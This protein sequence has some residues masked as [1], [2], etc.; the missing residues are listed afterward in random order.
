MAELNASHG[1]M[2]AKIVCLS[3][4]ASSPPPLASGDSGLLPMPASRT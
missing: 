2:A 4:N 3:E 1:Q